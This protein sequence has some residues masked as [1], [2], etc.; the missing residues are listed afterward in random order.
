LQTKKRISVILAGLFEPYNDLEYRLFIEALDEGFKDI[1]LTI[2]ANRKVSGE[3]IR[4]ILGKAG[5][6]RLVKGYYQGD[7]LDW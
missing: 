7:I 6:V 2:Q 5:S 4:I 3:K 1:F